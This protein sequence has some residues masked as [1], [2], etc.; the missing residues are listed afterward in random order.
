M[1]GSVGINPNQSTLWDNFV[2]ICAVKVLQDL[3][4]SFNA[5]PQL[6]GWKSSGG[7]DPCEESWTGISCSGSS[8]IQM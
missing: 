6:V 7:G 8:V 3:Y 2:K 1:I 4:M 5:P